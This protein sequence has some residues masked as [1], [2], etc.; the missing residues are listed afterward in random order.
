MG[1]KPVWPEEVEVKPC[2]ADFLG[3]WKPTAFFSA[4]AFL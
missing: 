4:M 3:R 1:I 2:E